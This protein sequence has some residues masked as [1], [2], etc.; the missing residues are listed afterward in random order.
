[1]FGVFHAM[2]FLPVLLS[3]IGPAP[4]QTNLHLIQEGDDDEFPKIQ[5]NLTQHVMETDEQI[6]MQVPTD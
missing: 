6:Y 3:L 5:I 4:Y 1:M 2:V